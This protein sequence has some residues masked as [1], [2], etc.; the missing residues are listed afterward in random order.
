[1][2]RRDVTGHVLHR[3]VDRHPR[4]DR[5]AGGVDVQVN[6]GLGVVELQEQHL[7]HD[8]V[9]AGVVH[10]PLQEDDAVL[11][12]TAVD[13]EDALFPAAALDHVRYERHGT[14]SVPTPAPVL[15]SAAGRG[16]D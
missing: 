13:V 4:G 3:V 16:G 11:E 2:V 5:A 1:A 10:H 15:S 6:V 7:R 8:Q 14:H 9:G 12:Q